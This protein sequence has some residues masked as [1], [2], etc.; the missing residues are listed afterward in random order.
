MITDD[1]EVSILWSYLDITLLFSSYVYLIFLSLISYSSMESI[2]YKDK[3]KGFGLIPFSNNKLMIHR[4]LKISSRLSSPSFS[5]STILSFGK[6]VIPVNSGEIVDGLETRPQPFLSFLRGE[7]AGEP[8]IDDSFL[9]TL[10]GS[11]VLTKQL[12]GRHRP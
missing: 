4:S 1:E 12:T 9:Q 5:P 3:V 11:P 10:T 7:S 8:A 2:L 6:V